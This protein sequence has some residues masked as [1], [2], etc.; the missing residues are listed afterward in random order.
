MRSRPLPVRSRKWN[1]VC[2]DG[3]F[4]TAILL[5]NFHN[6]AERESPEMGKIGNLQ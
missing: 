4:F 1:N 6:P 3:G 5:C 2:Q